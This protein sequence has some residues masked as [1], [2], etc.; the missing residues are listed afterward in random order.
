MLRIHGDRLSL[1][2]ALAAH[3]A[4]QQVQLPAAARSTNPGSSEAGLSSPVRWLRWRESNLK[5]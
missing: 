3:W 4:D 2:A 5:L 1:L